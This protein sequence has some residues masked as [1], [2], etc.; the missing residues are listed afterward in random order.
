MNR[1]QV[2]NLLGAPDA[3]G[4]T[5]REY[6][7][8]SIWKYGD[9]ELHFAQ[10]IDAL[11]LIHLNDFDVPSGG[12]SIRLDPWLITRLLTLPEAEERLTQNGVNYKMTDYEAED[13]TTCLMVGAGVKLLFRGE[14]E[15]LCVVSYSGPLPA[16]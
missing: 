13:D 6:R 14:D 3:L 1:E 8:P 16:K 15:N 4:G 10:G 2:E 5:S 7:K 12:K 11:F 9:V